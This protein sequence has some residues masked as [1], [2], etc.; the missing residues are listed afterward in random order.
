MLTNQSFVTIKAMSAD[1]YRNKGKNLS[2]NYSFCESPFGKIFIA[3]TLQGICSLEFSLNPQESHDR[4]LTLFPH[5]RL[6]CSSDSLQQNAL[7]IFSQEPQNL[8]DIKL[9]LKGTDF[10]LKVWNALLHIPWGKLSTYGAIATEIGHPKACRATGTAIGANPVA[11]IIPCHR[12]IKSSGDLGNYH[13]GADRKA[14]MIHWETTCRPQL[15]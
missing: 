4:L 11:V 12:V 8:S 13:W 6:T 15:P 1:E 2:I 9:H 5:A 14:A 3:S 7:S 10:Q